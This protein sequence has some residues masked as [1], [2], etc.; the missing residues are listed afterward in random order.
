M[1]YHHGELGPGMPYE[2]PYNSPGSIP[3]PI[4]T[5]YFG[6]SI[7]QR[8][9]KYATVFWKEGFQQKDM[10]ILKE[11]PNGQNLIKEAKARV[12][13]FEQIGADEERNTGPED[14]TCTEGDST[15]EETQNGD[16]KK[17]NPDSPNDTNSYSSKVFQP[18]VESDST[19]NNVQI[20]TRSSQ[21]GISETKQTGSN[22][23]LS[24]FGC[25][26]IQEDS[27]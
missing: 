20:S 6:L 1:E 26:K 9:I 14:S 3:A 13:F 15:Y 19:D 4:L 2:I 8:V 21:D 24:V 17:G 12:A 25:N 11:S 22:D 18:S 7:I 23:N 10:A 27:A 16:I 5:I